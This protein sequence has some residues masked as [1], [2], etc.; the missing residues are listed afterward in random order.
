MTALDGVAL[1]LWVLVITNVARSI[2]T[3]AKPSRLLSSVTIAVTWVA[4]VAG[5][6][7]G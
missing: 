3:G 7:G 6:L 1:V 5:L 2:P 4:L